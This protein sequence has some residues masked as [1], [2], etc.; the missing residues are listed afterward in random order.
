MLGF[1][2]VLRIWW[3][4]EAFL[5]FAGIRHLS[6]KLSSKRAGNLV[7][8]LF[9]L[10]VVLGLFVSGPALASIQFSS[11]R[12]S[13]VEGTT[14]RIVVT[15]TPEGYPSEATVLLRDFVVAGTREPIVLK[16]GYDKFDDKKIDLATSNVDEDKTFIIV[17]GAVGYA[18]TDS[19]FVRSRGSMGLDAL[20]V[21]V[22]GTYYRGKQ[23]YI[24][25]I[26][27]IA[28]N[29]YD[30]K[31]LVSSDQTAAGDTDGF[32]YGIS[33]GGGYEFN[34]GGF[35]F[36]PHGWV[37]YIRLDIDGYTEQASSPTAAGA[38]SVLKIEDQEIESLR[39]VL[40]GGRRYMR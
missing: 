11:D 31:R 4:R 8:L 2:A 22:Y 35:S 17:G 21:S 13:G 3:V 6:N 25:G 18:T 1:R 5:L 28:M 34:A 30:S 26:A 15:R 10:V 32:Q 16:W 29:S 23:V 27:S 39:S 14:I 9:G 12:Y 24:D 38:G 37:N 19:T 40:G 36:G 7:R 20:N 33:L